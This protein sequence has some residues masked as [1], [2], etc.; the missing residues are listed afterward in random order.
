MLWSLHTAFTTSP[1]TP[2]VE[3]LTG[4]TVR[5]DVLTSGHVVASATLRRELPAPTSTQTVSQD[6]FAAKLYTRPRSR[7][8]L[9]PSS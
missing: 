3:S 2:F 5:L 8:A 7:R 1:D 4:F 6:G 9:L